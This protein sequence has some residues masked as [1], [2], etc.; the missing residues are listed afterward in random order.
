MYVGRMKG[1]RERR[2]RPP[3]G[4]VKKEALQVLQVK[5]QDLIV[6]CRVQVTGQLNCLES[7]F[8][9]SSRLVLSSPP[10]SASLCR[11]NR[12]KRKAQLFI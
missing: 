10:P 4:Q 1:T 8:S 5:S 9:I 12:I 3:S 6:K 11:R 2:S 7:M